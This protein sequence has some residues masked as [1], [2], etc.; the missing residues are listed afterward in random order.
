MSNTEESRGSYLAALL[1]YP[2]AICF[3]EL[4][5]KGLDQYNT[6]LDISLLPTVLFSLATGFLL[7]FVFLL[8]KPVVLSRILSGITMF[9]LW[10]I[11]CVEFDCNVF[12]KIY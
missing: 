7:A 5:L 10:I 2:L 6:F 1:F 12:Y 3:L 9:L 4:L 11:F 8:I